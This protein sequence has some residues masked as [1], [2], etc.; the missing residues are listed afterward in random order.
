[1]GNAGHSP[2]MMYHLYLTFCSLDHSSLITTPNFDIP[3]DLAVDRFYTHPP[4]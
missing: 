4:G 1:M 3:I 2:K